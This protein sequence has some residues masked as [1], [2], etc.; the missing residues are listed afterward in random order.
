MAPVITTLSAAPQGTNQGS[1]GQTLT[2][3]GTG[4]TGSTGVRIGT[5]TV[6]PG[7]VTATQVTCVLPS[8]CGPTT[9]SV[10][11]PSGTSNALPFYYIDPPFVSG[12]A[13]VEGSAATPSAVTFTGESL[14]TT[15]RIQFGTVTGT[16]TTPVTSDVSVTATPIAVTPLGANPWFQSFGAAVRTAGG[17]ATVTNAIALFDTPTVTD[18]NP[19]TGSAGTLVIITGTAFVGSAVSV[20]FDG[21]DADFTPNSDTVIIATAPTGPTGAIDV[22]VTTPGGGSTPVTF[23]YT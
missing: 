9:V 4:L 21:V 1:Y 7:T 2:I 17:T 22:V 13:P 3:T 20:T 5:R 10:V 18:L 16:L 14:L 19:N 8:A 6:T 11:A 23:T 15:N 12:V